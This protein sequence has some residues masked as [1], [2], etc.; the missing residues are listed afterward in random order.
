M[1]MIM[2]FAIPHPLSRILVYAA[3]FP[4]AVNVFIMAAEYQHDAE[5][6]SQAIFWTTLSSAITLSALVALYR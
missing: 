6:A 1:A 4:V 5:F 2:L 3:G